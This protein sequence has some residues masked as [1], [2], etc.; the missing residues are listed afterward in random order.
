VPQKKETNN[1]D[2]NGHFGVTILKIR[3]IEKNVLSVTRAD[4]L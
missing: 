1:N 3:I 4:N 2:D